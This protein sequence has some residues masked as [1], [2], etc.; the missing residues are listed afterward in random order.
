M[1][2]EVENG[3]LSVVKDIENETIVV[4]PDNMNIKS[5]S[6]DTI[7]GEYP[8]VEKL[9]LSEGVE[10]LVIENWDYNCDENMDKKCIYIPN[11]VKSID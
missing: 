2:V 4:L 10:E 3:N 1:N 7:F 8:D 11:S 5:V 9:V 6:T